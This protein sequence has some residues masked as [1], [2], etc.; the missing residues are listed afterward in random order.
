MMKPF[1]PDAQAYIQ[2]LQAQILTLSDRSAMY[3]VEQATQAA[4]IQELKA[5]NAELTAQLKEKEVPN[6]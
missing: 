2:E 1:A 4:E 3:A 6:V 5:R